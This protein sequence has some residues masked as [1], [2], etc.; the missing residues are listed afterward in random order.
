MK[1]KL[2]YSI[3]VI[4]LLQGI[5]FS[6]AHQVDVTSE[7]KDPNASVLEINLSGEK[8][9]IAFADIY[10]IGRAVSYQGESDGDGSFTIDNIIPG[11]YQIT[12]QEP[13]RGEVPWVFVESCYPPGCFPSDGRFSSSPCSE[14]CSDLENVFT[15]ECA[16]ATDLSVNEKKKCYYSARIEGWDCWKSCTGNVN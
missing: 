15:D 10:V 13:E 11:D 1:A 9:I 3:A 8:E 4:F 7:T 16:E 14:K 2:L 5:F 12:L 6:C